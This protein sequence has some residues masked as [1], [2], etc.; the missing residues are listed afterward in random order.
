V[1]LKFIEARDYRLVN[2]P[3]SGTKIE[4]ACSILPILDYTVLSL[5]PENTTSL[6]P[7]TTLFSSIFVTPKKPNGVLYFRHD[8]WLVMPINIQDDFK[9]GRL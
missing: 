6:R 1:P 9:P 2:G 3:V 5:I 8:K 4:P 7:S